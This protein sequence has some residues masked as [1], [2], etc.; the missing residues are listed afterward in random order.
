[1]IHTTQAGSEQPEP[2]TIL[3]EQINRFLITRENNYPEIFS[4]IQNA[5]HRCIEQSLPQNVMQALDNIMRF[6]N[7]IERIR[8]FPDSMYEY[9]HFEFANYIIDESLGFIKYFRNDTENT[10][11]ILILTLLEGIF[12]YY[13]ESNLISAKLSSSS[14]DQIELRLIEVI[15]KITRC[16]SIKKELNKTETLIFQEIHVVK[17]YLSIIE[18]SLEKQ[19]YSHSYY[20]LQICKNI[21]E[22]PSEFD[23]DCNEI[24]TKLEKKIPPH[25]KKTLKIIY[26]FQEDVRQNQLDS[27]TL[28]K[29][30]KTFQNRSRNLKDFLDLHHLLYNIIYNH[31]SQKYH[32]ILQ[33]PETHYRFQDILIAFEFIKVVLDTGW[34]LLESNQESMNTDE[35]VQVLT[36]IYSALIHQKNLLPYAEKSDNSEKIKECC[37]TTI[38]NILFFYN[39]SH[40][41]PSDKFDITS[42]DEILIDLYL[43]LITFL[44]ENKQFQEAKN[45]IE[46]FKTQINHFSNEHHSLNNSSL[47][48]QLDELKSQCEQCQPQQKIKKAKKRNRKKSQSSNPVE[49]ATQKR[50][51]EEAS[52]ETS[53]TL[54]IS[55]NSAPIIPQFSE[56]KPLALEESLPTENPDISDPETEDRAPLFFQN[57]QSPHRE[58]IEEIF[59]IL[60]NYPDIQA[61][62]H[63]ESNY[64]HSPSY[65]NIILTSPDSAQIDD[66]I[67]AINRQATVTIPQNAD[68]RDNKNSPVIYHFQRNWNNIKIKFSHMEGHPKEVIKRHTES[69]GL[70]IDAAYYVIKTRKT[71]F[72][73][74]RTCSHID[75]G[76]LDTLQEPEAS[77]SID[78]TRIL[79]AIRIMS[80]T[81]FRLSDRV[82]LA[83]NNLFPEGGTKNLFDH[84]NPD[85]LY[86]EMKLLFYSGYAESNLDLLI[87]TG[88]FKNFFAALKLLSPAQYESTLRLVRETARQIDYCYYNHP[89]G[90]LALPFSLIYDAAHW[91]LNKT[92]TVYYPLTNIRLQK[93]NFPDHNDKVAARNKAYLTQLERSLTSSISF[94]SSEYTNT[95]FQQNQYLAANHPY[96]PQAPYTV[97]PPQIQ[98]FFLWQQPLIG[99]TPIVPPPQPVPSF[100]FPQGN[101]AAFFSRRETYQSHISN[102]R[103]WKSMPNPHT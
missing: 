93:G 76:I 50:E 39:Q 7:S 58:I 53:N 37:E 59:K 72:G 75:H 92:Q 78:S 40:I 8:N 89:Q 4:E 5:F 47:L 41:I 57:E 35:Y 103:N 6:I 36:H 99:Y 51:Q 19:Q 34:M 70:T 30:T 27:K 91:E 62:L 69:I 87:E 21:M 90:A 9:L 73:D 60:E 67:Q 44:I 10:Y 43:K 63:G 88:I 95:D 68:Y 23:N 22:Y 64:R 86:F 77:F 83:I 26:D 49:E 54:I 66:F 82:I 96:F 46:N 29:L 85:R 81:G 42:L 24:Y 16:I 1:M 20:Y 52:E 17:C 80:S 101:P 94:S 25:I 28:A 55:S 38:N 65:L 102:P 61:Y 13:T 74:P 2:S 33:D 100:N 45:N 48:S 12:T 11:C 79:N 84:E 56:S 14:S 15:A 31:I 18:N 98:P 71:Y 32:V 97:Q 3:H